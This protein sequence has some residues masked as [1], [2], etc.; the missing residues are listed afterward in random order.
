MT[1]HEY[2]NH[3]EVQI[4]DLLEMA[5][6]EFSPLDS[7]FFHR[8]TA[9]EKWSAQ[10]CFAH[11]NSQM[12]KYFPKIERAIHL[13]KAR[14]WQPTETVEHSWPG[15]SMLRRVTLTEPIRIKKAK[16]KY[17]YLGRTG[18][19]DEY[20]SFLINL[21]ILLRLLRQSR[22]IDINRP[23]IPAEGW[24]FFKFRMGELFEIFVRHAERHIV[25]AKSAIQ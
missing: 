14:Q 8:R 15:N 25:Q 3:L 16:K 20:K 21:E 9:P 22:A 12:E 19:R 17:N 24:L 18:R 6:A 4:R 5:R 13:G 11:L 7:S 2:I 23:R 10:E 1:Q